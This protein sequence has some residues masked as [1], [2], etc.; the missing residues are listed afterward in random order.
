MKCKSGLLL[1][2]GLHSPLSDW[3]RLNNNDDAQKKRVRAS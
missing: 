3:M 2:G 1:D